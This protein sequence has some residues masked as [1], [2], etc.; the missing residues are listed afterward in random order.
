MNLVSVVTC[1]LIGNIAG[2]LWTVGYEG[3][4]IGILTTV[5]TGLWCKD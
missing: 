5:L 1:L 4:T 3:I 2:E